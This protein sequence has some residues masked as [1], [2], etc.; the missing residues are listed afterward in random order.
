MKIPNDPGEMIAIIDENDD[1]IGRNTRKE[2][3]E[4]GLLHREVYVYIIS[5]G[6]IL[7]QKRA[8]NHL[9]DHSVG[10]HFPFDQDYPEAAVRETN[11]EIGVRITKSDLAYL[12]AEHLNLTSHERFNDRIAKIFLVRK[13]ISLSDITI[14]AGEVDEVKFFDKAQLEKLLSEKERFMTSCSKKIITK[15]ILPLM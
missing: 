1:V 3:H 8:D 7:L 5:H 14:Q 4:K 11:E 6:R 13:D 2:A 9:W 15:Y 12:G 10:G